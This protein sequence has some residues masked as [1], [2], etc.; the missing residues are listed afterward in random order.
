[1]P[2]LFEDQEGP[3]R[4]RKREQGEEVCEVQGEARGPD[5]AGKGLRTQGEE[6]QDQ[7]HGLAVNRT[8]ISALREVHPRQGRERN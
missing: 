7:G 2:G 1:M 3:H 5:C 6:K 4:Q 8:N